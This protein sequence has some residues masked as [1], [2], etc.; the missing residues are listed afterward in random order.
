MKL[1][2][3][4]CYLTLCVLVGAALG[5]QPGSGL[6]GPGLSVFQLPLGG[7]VTVSLSSPGGQGGGQQHLPQA[8]PVASEAHGRRHL[9]GRRWARAPRGRPPRT[10]GWGTMPGRAAPFLSPASV[11]SSVFA[12]LACPRPCPEPGPPSLT[13]LLPTIPHLD[14]GVWTVTP[15]RIWT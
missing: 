7:Q 12:L 5:P 3:L 4:F 14:L 13:L 10:L 11:E 8:A 15:P 6:S 9:A 2:L 1:L